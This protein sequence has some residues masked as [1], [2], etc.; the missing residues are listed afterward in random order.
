[1]MKLITT[2]GFRVL[3]LL[4]VFILMS[5][6]AIKSQDAQSTEELL[7]AAGFVMIPAETPEEIANLNTLTPLKVEFSVKDNKPLY[8][9]ADPYNCK[10]VYTG[11][12]AAYQRYEQLNVEQNIAYEEQDAA[13][14]NE[15]AMVNANM[16]GWL[17]GPWGW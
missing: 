9:Y 6:A 5:C 17:G 13:M 11:D 8:W 14:M 7:S 16:W 15:Q 2:P 12:Q 10:C 3:A 4:S 1:M